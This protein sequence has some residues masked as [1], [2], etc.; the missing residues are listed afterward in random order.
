MDLF[1]MLV[2]MK[3]TLDILVVMLKIVKLNTSNI[4]K[5]LSVLMLKSPLTV[6]VMLMDVLI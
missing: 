6:L 2:E 1:S 3:L 5:T 4:G